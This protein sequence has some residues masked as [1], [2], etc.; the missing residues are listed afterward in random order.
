MDF[1][2]R[3]LQLNDFYKDYLSLLNQLTPT[4]PYNLIQFN[5]IFEEINDNK[6]IIILVLEVN[7]KIMASGTLIIEQ[8]FL[9]NGGKVGH[10]EDIVVDSS[11]RG[12]NIGQKLVEELAN[13]AL[14]EYRCYKVILD[15]L[16]ELQKFYEKCGFT[17]KNIQ[18]SKYKK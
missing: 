7:E 14:N 3:K 9:R 13:I 15:C 6:N 8:K 12:K 17:Y 16:P 4:T 10:I 18:M 1:K 5:N 2:F 11:M